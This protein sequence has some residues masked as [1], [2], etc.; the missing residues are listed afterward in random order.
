MEV[1]RYLIAALYVMAGCAVTIPL[2]A[3][4]DG[5]S[6]ER[7]RVTI[8]QTVRTLTISEEQ[9][10]E[11]QCY[12]ALPAQNKL[13]VIHKDLHALL[14]MLASERIEIGKLCR[15]SHKIRAPEC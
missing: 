13:F 10:E 2:K 15:T 14:L 4:V 3:Q 12:R 11:R 8:T 9:T 1:N 5:A 6:M 7:C